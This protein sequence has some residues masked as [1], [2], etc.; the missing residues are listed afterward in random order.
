MNDEKI[1]PMDMLFAGHTAREVYEAKKNGLRYIV[2]QEVQNT[3]RATWKK[4]QVYL[5]SDIIEELDKLGLIPSETIFIFTG[6]RKHPIEMSECILG[7]ECGMVFHAVAVHS[8]KI[9]EIFDTFEDVVWFKDKEKQKVMEKLFIAKVIL[10]EIGHFVRRGGNG[11]MDLSSE[12]D[13]EA[14][15]W[16]KIKEYADAEEIHDFQAIH[17]MLL[18]DYWLYLQDKKETSLRAEIRRLREQIKEM[19]AKEIERWEEQNKK[20]EEIIKR[21]EKVSGKEVKA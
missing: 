19:K 6:K 7:E 12:E 9:K 15:S 17:Q 21:A 18:M 2:N 20:L 13:A 3:K 16:E 4:E 10:H 14:Y 8:A 1:K 5:V 11:M